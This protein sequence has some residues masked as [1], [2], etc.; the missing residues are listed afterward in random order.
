MY[1]KLFRD[2]LNSSINELP[3]A[4]RWFWVTLNL[5]A[6]RE[7]IVHG[8]IS[9]L[10]RL[11]NVSLESAAAAIEDLERPDPDSTDQE[12]EGR[13]IVRLGPNTWKITN[14]EKYQSIR[15]PEEIRAQQR[16][17]WRR[18][19][20]NH[21]ITGDDDEPQ[22]EAND[23]Q[24]PLTVANGSK[25]GDDAANKNGGDAAKT[26]IPFG[27][28]AGLYNEIL[29]HL[30]PK[31]RAEDSSR[32]W[33]MRKAML[34]ARWAEGCNSLDKWREFFM[35]VA[36]CPFL[37]GEKGWRASFDWLIRPSNFAK[38]SEGSYLPMAKPK[39]GS[40]HRFEN[41]TC[42]VCGKP[43]ELTVCKECQIAEFG[44][45]IDET[46]QQT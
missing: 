7:G 30:L 24:R 31:V 18:W 46:T 16:E 40:P 37:L 1:V 44:G 19:K 34:K 9:A 11:A 20:E 2:I 12:N 35:L 10:A 26:K 13:R 25:R 38:V 22:M 6:N 3:I 21:G 29:G 17:R 33:T 45:L 23:D 15:D 43:S 4:T 39:P 36:K 32:A 5:V 42:A 8:T 27:E 14:F 41:G 28:I